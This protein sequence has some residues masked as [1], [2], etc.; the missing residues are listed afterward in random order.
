SGIFFAFLYSLAITAFNVHNVP[1][2]AASGVLIGFIHGGVVGFML[3]TAVAE[4]HPLPQFQKAGFSVG[5][6]HWIAH[7][8]YGF[9]VGLIFGL[10]GL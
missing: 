6:A 9:L 1:L 8:V 7:V 4:H 10:M 2:T 5:V 3:V